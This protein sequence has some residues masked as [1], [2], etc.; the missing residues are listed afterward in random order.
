[1]YWSTP[2]PWCGAACVTMRTCMCAAQP[3]P[4]PLGAVDAGHAMLVQQLAPG[5]VGEDH[6][7]GDDLVERRAALAALDRDDVVA[8]RKIEIDAIGLLR[9]AG[10]SSR[11]WPCGPVPAPAPIATAGPG[12]PCAD[13]R[14]YRFAA[15]LRS[16]ARRDRC[17][18]GCWR[19]APPR[20]WSRWPA[21]TSRPDRPAHTA[22]APGRSGRRPG[23]RR[24]PPRPAAW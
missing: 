18:A 7:F 5:A 8:H 3:P 14:R 21:P 17:G 6:Q 4:P 15:P 20:L 24:R 10:R 13:S 19:S 1:M 16:P 2:R 9:P 11:A 22:T 12:R 23:C